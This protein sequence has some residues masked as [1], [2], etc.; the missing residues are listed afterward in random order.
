MNYR[1]GFNACQE[2]A[3]SENTLEIDEAMRIV[4]NIYPI[5]RRQLKRLEALKVQR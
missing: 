3:E 2:L 5:L 1:I 4:N